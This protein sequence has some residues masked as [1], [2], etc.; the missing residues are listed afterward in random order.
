MPYYSKEKCFDV[1]DRYISLANE[2]GTTVT[3]LALAWVN[4]RGFVTSNIIGATSIE[5]LQQDIS[6][7]NITLSEDVYKKVD[8][9]FLDG[10]NV[11]CFL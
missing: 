1:V 2:I 5:Q 4:D 3:E 6:S 10:Q 8:E 9:I 7:A 11:A